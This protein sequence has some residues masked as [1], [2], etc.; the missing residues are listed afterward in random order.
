MRFLLLSLLTWSVALAGLSKHI[1][2]YDIQAT[3]NHKT[4]TITGNETLTWVNDSPDTVSTLQFHLY[5]NAFRNTKSTFFT[6]SG[7]QLRGDQFKG[8]EWGWIE[9]KKM[10]LA[11]GADV[12]K[13]IRF[14]HPDDNNAE[15]RTVIEVA[16][17]QA[18]KPGE[19]IQVAIDFETKMPMVFARTGFRKD[20]YLVGQWFPKI[21]V[22]E[23]AGFRYSTQGAWNC[24]QFH[25]NSEFFANFGRYDVQLTVPSEMVIGATGEQ[26]KRVENVSNKTTTYGFHQEDVTDFAWTVQPNYIRVERMFEAAKETTAKEIAY[27]AKLGG[28]PEEDVRLSDVKMIV[29]MQPEHAEQIERTFHATRAALKH[30][31]LWYGRYP[32]KTITVVDPPYGAGGAGG[33]EYPTFITAGTSWKLPPGSRGLE[34]VTVHEFGHQFWMQLVATNEF[35]ESPMDEGLN[36]YSTTLIMDKVYGGIGQLPI[37]LFG[38]NVWDWLHLPGISDLS[39]DRAAFLMSP[40][41]DDLLRK[42]WQYY[43]SQSYGVNSYM[44][45][46][47]TLDTLERIVGHDT[48]ARL[49]RTYHTRY[50][51]RHPTARDFA[52]VASEVSGQNL[53]WFFN[54]FFFG[55]RLLDYR[56]GEVTSE[57]RRTPMGRFE[58]GGTFQITTRK[59]ARKADDANDENKAFRK[60]YLGTVKIQRH[61]DAVAPVEIVIRFK[62]GSVEKRQWDGEYRWVK[63]TFVRSSE[64]ESV[65]ID[66]AKKYRLDVSFANNSWV[67]KYQVEVSTH[68]SA[69]VLFWL[70]NLMLILTSVA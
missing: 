57:Q 25:A 42:S 24:H 54:Q 59:D 14:I 60:E 62:D 13:A 43:D 52:K 46:G 53:D 37:T 45:M 10:R 63:Y 1:A 3:L 29:L 20:F 5:M 12:T 48:M 67:S 49:M 36:T 55:N 35:E 22:W 31:G 16:L 58:K 7:G 44:R 68:W 64:I 11:S 26:T 15:D 34:E 28:V 32:Y 56:I 8:D 4:H 6:E 51:F 19:T 39:L 23:T 18:V 61:G 65:D 38:M 70:Q 41:D 27:E 50:R 2:S 66:P 30:F 33:M 21:G 9:V 47:V 69:N 17:P 40:A